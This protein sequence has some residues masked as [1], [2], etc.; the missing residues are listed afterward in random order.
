M[1]S[2]VVVGFTSPASRFDPDT[3]SYE[4]LDRDAHSWVEVLFPRYGWIPFDP[5]PGR[6]V[7][8]SASVSSP[9]YSSDGVEITI[10]P[11]ISPAPIHPTTI[12]D[13][14]RA[15]EPV[16]SAGVGTSDGLDTW[17]LLTIPAALLLALGTPLALKGARRLRR[18]RGGE[19]ARVLGAARELESLLED[20]G[21]PIDPATSPAERARIVWRDLGID[22]ERIYGLASAARFA[23]GEPPP[24]S[25]HAAWVELARIRRTLGWRM[26]ARA[27]LSV[28]SLRRG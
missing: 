10:A 13:P 26:R 16:P 23:P 7:P 27:G 11:G 9:N 21:R 19:R 1:K 14:P 22:A 24:G 25:G 6:S 17:W 28:R 5:T 4:I 18:R 20:A 8:N 12:P 2:S 3:A 15:N